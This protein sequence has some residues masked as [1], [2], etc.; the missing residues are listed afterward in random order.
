[1]E[2][3]DLA[4]T[5][6]AAG[7]LLGA[8]G[9]AIFNAAMVRSKHAIA[10]LMYGLAAVGVGSVAWTVIGFSV[11]YGES[12]P[13]YGGLDHIGLTRL[14][15]ASI[16]FGADAPIAA[17]L[18]TMAVAIVAAVALTGAAAD[19]MRFGSMLGFLTLWLIAVPPLVVRATSPG[20]WLTELGALDSGGGAL[21]GVATGASALGLVLVLGPRHKWRK[22][23]VVP[24]NRPLAL[25]GALL[26]WV[27]WLAIAAGFAI[28]GGRVAEA[29]VAV[30]FGAL[31]GMAGWMML[32]KRLV[33]KVTS[34]GAVSGAVTGLVATTAGA[35][36]LDLFRSLI[37]GFVASAVA[38]IAIRLKY[39]LGYDDALDV[40]ALHLFGGAV[41]MLLLGV[42][43]KVTGPDA[44]R[45]LI[46]GDSGALLGWQALAVLAVAAFAFVATVVCA[47]IVR[48]SIGLRVTPEEESIG[49]DDSQHGESAYEIRD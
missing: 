19:R 20:G 5:A 16:A 27:G 36:Y 41:G 25:A 42:M 24:H 15:G 9:L 33:G 45:G 47:W 10:M 12:S 38:A 49:L 40:V 13:W 14:R 11:A 39:R 18:F 17:A 43:P 22:R 29:V 21:L 8:A 28:P 26:A 30:H 23:R 37:V 48:A 34:I 2:S 46:N 44:G 31:G 32:D 3:H 6:A 4:L 7:A 35:A 1:M